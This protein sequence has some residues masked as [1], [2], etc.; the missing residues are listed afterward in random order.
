MN[1]DFFAMCI[2]YSYDPVGIETRNHVF[3]KSNQ[4]YKSKIEIEIVTALPLVK[5]I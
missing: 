2:A 1:I 5:M 3:L 4:S